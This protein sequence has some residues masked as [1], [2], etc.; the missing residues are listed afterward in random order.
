MTNIIQL[1]G[2]KSLKSSTKLFYRIN[3]KIIN[4]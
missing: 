3:Y 1:L 2:L 4:Y